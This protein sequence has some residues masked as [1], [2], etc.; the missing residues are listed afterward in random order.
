MKK[1]FEHTDRGYSWN[2]RH[3]YY[4][5]ESEEE[6]EMI[7]NKELSQWKCRQEGTITARPSTIVLDGYAVHGGKKFYA[8][9]ITEYERYGESCRSYW[10]YVKPGTIK[11]DETV[12]TEGWWV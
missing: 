11:E 10:H 9:G 7:K 3:E 4:L 5:C 1:L 8:F 2:H 12:K 6:Y